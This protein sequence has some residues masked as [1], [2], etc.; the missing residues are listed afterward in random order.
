MLRSVGISFLVFCLSSGASQAAD[1]STW[2]AAAEA[3]CPAH[4]LEWTCDG[5]WDD[6]LAAFEATLPKSTQ[7]K[8]LK[9]ADYSRRCAKEVA[10]FSC[11]MSMHVDAMHRLGLLRRFVAYGCAH[12][13]CE[14]AASCTRL[15]GPAA[16]ALG[17]FTTDLSRGPFRRR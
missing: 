17:P 5:C 9:I 10:G 1:I 6:F 16:K 8:I 12:Y 14:Y 13:T 4:H 7:G 11:E 15:P 2:E 3:R